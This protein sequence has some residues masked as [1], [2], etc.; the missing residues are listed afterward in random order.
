MDKVSPGAKL[1]VPG[2]S[3][4]KQEH[5]IMERQFYLFG[6]EAFESYALDRFAEIRDEIEKMSDV[7]VL[8]HQ[9]SFDELVQR[10]AA[11]YAFRK[12]Q[13]D[14]SLQVVDL[15]SRM[16]Q[17]GKTVFAEYT[18]PFSGN[19]YYLGLVPEHGSGNDPKLRILLKKNTFTFEINTCYH[20][21]ELPEGIREVVKKEYVRIKKFIQDSLY[22]LNE[23]VRHYNTE[24]EKLL[25]LL[26]ADKM[27]RAQRLQ[28]IREAINF[29]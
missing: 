16:T 19:P 15:S 6:E 28:K 12:M 25:V 1:R 27:R 7:E 13:V 23:T 10:M 24:L 4:K 11:L 8:M 2:P 5:T 29:T 14:F 18:L 9:D 20:H 17:Y 22:N 3:K 26:L 21:E